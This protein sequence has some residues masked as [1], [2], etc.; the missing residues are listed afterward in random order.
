MQVIL[1]VVSGVCANSQNKSISSKNLS[2]S[3]FCNSMPVKDCFVSRQKPKQDVSFGGLNIFKT[4]KK[5]FKR[6]P[7]SLKP[8]EL[9]KGV[10]KNLESKPFI[11]ANQSNG[12]PN[13]TFTNRALKILRKLDDIGISVSDPT[14]T[15]Q[16]GLEY[17]TKQRL[18]SKVKSKIASGLITKSEGDSLISEIN[19]AGKLPQ[20]LA[21]LEHHVDIAP[22]NIGEIS[23]HFNIPEVPGIPTIPE[24][25]TIPDIDISSHL[26][27][28]GASAA[29][30]AGDLLDNLGDAFEHLKD[31]IF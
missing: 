20:D 30:H 9:A 26:T 28:H 10:E 27:E 11:T 19:F 7:E 4:V 29:E 16:G 3:S 31:I 17:T 12:G 1:S 25:P 5:V 14:P 23:D 6:L 15:P 13:P 22:H 2:K 18:I 8:Q 21:L 24:I